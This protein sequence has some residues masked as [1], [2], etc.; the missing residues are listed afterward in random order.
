MKNFS[1][2]IYCVGGFQAKD[3]STPSEVDIAIEKS[4][5]K[6]GIEPSEKALKNI[7]DYASSYEALESEST[8]HVEMI[9]N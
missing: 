8:G 5:T 6:M 3:H 4:L 7:L 2:L 1:T 9:L